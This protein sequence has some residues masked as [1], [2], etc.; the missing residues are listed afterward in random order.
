M[1]E[2]PFAASRGRLAR[3]TMLDQLRKEDFEPLVGQNVKVTAGSLSA[4]LEVAEATALKSPSPRA[5]PPFRV[6]LRSRE[7]WRA[8]Q[9]MFRIAH[10][11]LG[12]LELFAVP[13]G[14]DGQG[15]CYEILF[16]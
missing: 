13:I 9:G 1:A 6:I 16:N 7:G 11:T 8:P 14:P 10:P 5:T 4:E 15:L 12:D 2:S 3:N